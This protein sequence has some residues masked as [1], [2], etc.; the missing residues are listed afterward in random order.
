MLLHGYTSSAQGNWVQTG[1]AGRLAAAGRRV[2]MPDMRG[3][4]PGPKP[5]DPDAYPADALTDDGLALIAHL[6]LGDYDLGGYSL[7]ARIAARMLAL[8]ATPGVR[9]WAGPGSSRSSTR[10]GAGVTTGAC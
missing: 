1:I 9:S 10:R 3:H 4:G 7:G 8:G 2:I 6:E 5:H